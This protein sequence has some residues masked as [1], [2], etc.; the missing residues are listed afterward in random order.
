M[1]DKETGSIRLSDTCQLHAGDTLAD[2]SAYPPGEIKQFVDHRNGWQWLTIKNMVVEEYYV[3]ISL[4]YCAKA[5]QQIELLVY[6]DPFDL[7]AGWDSWSEQRELEMLAVLRVW[8]CNELGREGP[9]AGET[10]RHLMIPK[11][12]TAP[13]EFSTDNPLC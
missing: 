11:R 10:H 1:I 2:T 4:G 8:L 5:L 12:G 9:F 6:H 13:S 7:T 3:I